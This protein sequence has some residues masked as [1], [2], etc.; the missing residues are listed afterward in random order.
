MKIFIRSFLKKNIKENNQ[1]ILNLEKK[2]GN[3]NI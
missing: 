3:L 1:E 2:S